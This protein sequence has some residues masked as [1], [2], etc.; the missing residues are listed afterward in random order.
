VT[1]LK[2][3][4]HHGDEH[5][6]EDNN[7]ANGVGAEHEE[8][9]EPEAEQTSRISYLVNLVLLDAGR[10]S[11]SLKNIQFYIGIARTAITAFN[12]VLCFVAPSFVFIEHLKR[13][14]LPWRSSKVVSLPLMVQWV[15][16][17]NLA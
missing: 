16:T 6:Q 3:I 11:S 10:H 1:C 15:V 5:V 12:F 14:S 13:Y 8:G 4:G 17:S 2:R 9:P 7:V